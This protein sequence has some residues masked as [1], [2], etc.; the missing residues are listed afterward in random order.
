MPT[1]TITRTID[2]DDTP[3]ATVTCK[4]RD[5][6]VFHLHGAVY[7]AAE[8]QGLRDTHAAWNT[9]RAALRAIAEGSPTITLRLGTQTIRFT[10]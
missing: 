5:A 2:G 3:I 10:S 9:L 7:E 1:Y 6:A 4:R 8:G